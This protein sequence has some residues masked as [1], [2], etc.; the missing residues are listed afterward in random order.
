MSQAVERMP[1]PVAGRVAYTRQK[2][3]LDDALRRIFDFLVASIGLIIL[4]PWII[5]ITA[6]IRRDSPG[7][8]LY[9]GRR[10]GRY[11][12]EFKILKFRTM[13]ER[14]ESYGGNPVTGAEDDRITPLGRWLRN[15]KINELPQLWNVIKGD[16]SLVGPRPEDPDIVDRDWPLEVRRELLSVRPGVTSPA[17]VL[18]RDEESLLIGDDPLGEY[19]RNVLPT[20]LRLDLLYVRNRNFFTDLDVIF[21]TFIALV[22]LLRS[23]PIPETRLFFGPLAEFITRYFNWF[24]VDSLVGFLAVGLSGIIWRTTGPLN[25]GVGTAIFVGLMIGLLFGLFNS[26]LGLTRVSWSRASAGDVVFLGISAFLATVALILSQAMFPLPSAIPVG[27]SVV[28]GLL[29]FTG[30]VMVRYRERILTGVATRWFHVRGAATS[31]G[32][33]VLIVGAGSNGEL[34][35]WF[36]ARGDLAHIFTVVGFV[37]DDPRKQGLQIN[38]VPVLGDTS[39]LSDLVE[40]HDIG[41]ILFAI[42]NIGQADRARILAGCQKSGVRVVV[43][44]DIDQQLKT[45]IHSPNAQHI[46]GLQPPPSSQVE[47]ALAGLSE[48]VNSQ[49]WESAQAWLEQL[50]TELSS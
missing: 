37:D 45:V 33:R 39:N 1:F 42:N 5:L 49:D 4:L 20:K 30:F 7:P 35:T 26:C 24:L 11:G 21:F 36:L 2:N 15:T 50:R 8:V 47:E 10:V 44:P 13:Y 40:R 41:L 9:R 28:T 22:P 34:V 12:R 19:L 43:F 17:S 29:A 16:M 6:M 32:E 25:I 38:T 48:S 27:M 46:P 3:W 23:L 14:P 31:L 18:Y